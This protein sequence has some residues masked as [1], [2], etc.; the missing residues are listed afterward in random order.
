VLGTKF[1]EGLDVIENVGHG[2]VLVGERD[3]SKWGRLP[4]VSSAAPRVKDAP[5]LFAPHLGGVWGVSQRA[6][7]VAAL[8]KK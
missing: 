3:P 5:K 6:G 2:G 8:L 7:T 1:E 4:D